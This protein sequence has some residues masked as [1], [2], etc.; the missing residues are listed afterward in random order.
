M[1]HQMP[2]FLVESYDIS[3]SLITVYKLGWQQTHG[4]VWP[5][6]SRNEHCE[7]QNEISDLP[8]FSMVGKW[9]HGAV[10]VISGKPRVT[11]QMTVVV[12]SLY[13]CVRDRLWILL[14]SMPIQ[15]LG[16]YCGELMN[17]C[18]QRDEVWPLNP[19]T[20]PRERAYVQSDTLLSLT[21]KHHFLQI[22]QLIEWVLK[23]TGQWTH[24]HMELLGRVRVCYVLHKHKRTIR[25]PRKFGPLPKLF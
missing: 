9:N 6:F 1:S 23:V 21:P 19:G 22:S 24:T 10:C 8:W 2:M 25:G 14:V 4:T 13:E 18:Q 15:K 16:S 5:E 17:L 12:V 3:L 7:R 20:T 11:V